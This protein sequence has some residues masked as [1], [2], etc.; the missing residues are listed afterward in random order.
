MMPT[1]TAVGTKLALMIAGLVN[2]TMAAAMKT[3]VWVAEVK[4]G[5]TAKTLNHH[6]VEIKN[7]NYLSVEIEPQRQGNETAS[8][9]PK[10]T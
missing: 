8:G 6:P 2:P 1:Q 5:R 7:T 10:V 9:E 3:L 4:T